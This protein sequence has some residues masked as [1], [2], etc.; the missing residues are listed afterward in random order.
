MAQSTSPADAATTRIGIIVWSAHRRAAV[1][2]VV[3]IYIRCGAIKFQQCLP[4]RCESRRGC[5]QYV[6]KYIRAPAALHVIKVVGRAALW[7]LDIGCTF[8]DIFIYT[9]RCSRCWAFGRV[10]AI[11]TEHKKKQ[12]WA[13]IGRNWCDLMMVRARVSFA[14]P[15]DGTRVLHVLSAYRSVGH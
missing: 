11:H 13:G 12:L 10:T 6:R 15:S 3:Y 1:R 5:T 8:I 4:T 7:C 2:R 14:P 9:H